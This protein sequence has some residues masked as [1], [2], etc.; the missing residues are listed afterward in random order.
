MKLYHVML[1]AS[2][3]LWACTSSAQDGSV[4]SFVGTPV[5]SV[6]SDG[7][8]GHAIGKVTLDLNEKTITT[9]DAV[10]PLEICSDSEKYFCL[11]GEGLAFAVEKGTS[12]NDKWSYKGYDFEVLGKQEISIFGSKRQVSVI[13]ARRHGET[14]AKSVAVSY[15]SSTDGLLGFTIQIGENEPDVYFLKGASG[16]AA[17]HKQ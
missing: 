6:G 8:V 11:F 9:Q 2:A 13:A 4:Y 17:D 1:L 14:P 3:S 10:L 5:I 16:Y 12:S 7:S 15:Y